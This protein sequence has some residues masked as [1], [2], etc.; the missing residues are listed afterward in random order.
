M[1]VLENNTTGSFT[2]IIGAGTYFLKTEI[3]PNNANNF[4]FL[5]TSQ[6]LSV[7]FA[8]YAA[9]SANAAND[10]DKDSLNE[11][12]SLSAIN[13]KLSIS[14]GNQVNI[15]TDTANEI[16]NLTL[17]SNNLQLSRNWRQ[18]RFKQIRH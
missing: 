10:F 15:D 17:T 6:L 14:K 3:D 7:P 12:Q 5:G 11:L 2:N 8:L 13:N 18:C 1:W 9:K 4:I 16:Q